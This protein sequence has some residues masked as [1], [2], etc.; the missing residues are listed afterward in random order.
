MKTTYYAW[1]NPDCNGIDPI[2]VELS[3]LE[4][5]A[6]VRSAESK[7]RYF[8]KLENDQNGTATIIESTA[9]SY[10]AWKKEKNRRE[11]LKR[12]AEGKPTVSYHALIRHTSPR[13]VP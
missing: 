8:I 6:L 7:G 9:T 4:F 13:G 5:L 2:W 11:Y 10:L 3:G 12:C 1:E